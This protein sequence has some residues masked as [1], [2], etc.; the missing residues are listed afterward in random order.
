MLFRSHGPWT[1]T[2]EWPHDSMA[3]STGCGDARTIPRLGPCSL[4]R[5]GVAQ[6]DPRIAP[7]RTVEIRNTNEDTNG[8]WIVQSAE[9]FIHIDGRYQVE[10]SCATDGKGQNKPSAVRPSTTG[11][12]P[13]INVSERTSGAKS[14]SPTSTSLAA[15]ATMISQT[16]T[17]FKVTP[18]RW[19]GK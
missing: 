10:F 4:L 18:R 16:Q 14:Y 3:G 17:G 1:S 5:T 7:W 6:G 9:H 2:S 13:V 12:S 19:K 11:M 8:Y 15:P